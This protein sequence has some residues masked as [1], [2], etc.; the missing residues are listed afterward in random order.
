MYLNTEK[1]MFMLFDN[2]KF[3]LSKFLTCGTY[4]KLI[5]VWM[6]SPTQWT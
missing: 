3:D 5:L 6:A 2:M 1:E 4:F